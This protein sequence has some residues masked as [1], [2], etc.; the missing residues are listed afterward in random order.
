MPY[1]SGLRTFGSEFWN[2]VVSFALSLPTTVRVC[3]LNTGLGYMTRFLHVAKTG[4]EPGLVCTFLGRSSKHTEDPSGTNPGPVEGR[5]S[6]LRYPRSPT[7]GTTPRMS[8]RSCMDEAEG[9]A[10]TTVCRP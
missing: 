7:T 2:G 9:C 1:E 8:K 4:R 3:L 10:G 6:S 5:C